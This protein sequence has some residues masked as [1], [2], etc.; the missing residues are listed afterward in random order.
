MKT[1]VLRTLAISALAPLTLVLWVIGIIATAILTTTG[2][3]DQEAMFV[4]VFGGAFIAGIAF[5]VIC[6][7]SLIVTLL[8]SLQPNPTDVALDI[9]TAVFVICGALSWA[10]SLFL[11]V[12]FIF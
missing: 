1:I 12:S 6:F 2:I 11:I 10:A 4:G 5:A 9:L 8:L 7:V 3:L